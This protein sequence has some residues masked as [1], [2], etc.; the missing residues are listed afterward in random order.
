MI[1][2]GDITLSQRKTYNVI[3]HDAQKQVKES[4]NKLLFYFSITDLKDRAGI[5]STNNKELKKTL[6]NLDLLELKLFMKMAT[7]VLST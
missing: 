5:H 7:G 6:I 2:N 1:A 3:L 4:P